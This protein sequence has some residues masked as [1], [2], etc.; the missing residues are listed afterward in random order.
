MIG[1]C[2]GYVGLVEV[3]KELKYKESKYID[4]T[5]RRIVSTMGIVLMGAQGWMSTYFL[6]V[7]PEGCTWMGERTHGAIIEGTD[8]DVVDV[9]TEAISLSSI[10]VSSTDLARRY[11]GPVSWSGLVGL[12]LI[13]MVYFL[14]S[15]F[16]TYEI[17]RDYAQRGGIWPIYLKWQDNLR[18]VKM[19][20]DLIK[21]IK[22]EKRPL[23]KMAVCA[24]MRLLMP[25]R[26]RIQ[27]PITALDFLIARSTGQLINPRSSGSTERCDVCRTPL[28]ITSNIDTKASEGT[29]PPCEYMRLSCGH[30]AHLPCIIS[31]LCS[32]QDF[33]CCKESKDV[34]T[35]IYNRIKLQPSNN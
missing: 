8:Q 20:N 15:A 14:M 9:G 3:A 27:Y 11:N 35:E 4:M 18:A 30:S 17:Y 23:S 25:G 2:L 5:A 1:L 22:D 21:N 10:A 6:W 31:T 19:F 13:W 34:R 29:L 16:I 26:M 24:V 7:R 12:L 33:N 32:S 28:S